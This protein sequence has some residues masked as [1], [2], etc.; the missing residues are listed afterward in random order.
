MSLFIV[1]ATLQFNI[2]VHARPLVDVEMYCMV[3]ATSITKTQ[4]EIYIS[5]YIF[6]FCL[7]CYCLA[8][9]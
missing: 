1:P 9:T 6:Y 4:M 2:E 7:K 5:V 3:V 8:C